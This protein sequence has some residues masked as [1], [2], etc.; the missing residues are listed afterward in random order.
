MNESE[1]EPREL[2]AAGPKGMPHDQCVYADRVPGY[3]KKG[4][5]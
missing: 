2:D 5:V 4:G 1:A 3:D